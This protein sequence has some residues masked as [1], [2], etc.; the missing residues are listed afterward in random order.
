MP[1][2]HRAAVSVVTKAEIEA[3]VEADGWEDHDVQRM[4]VDGLPK[5]E[6]RLESYP[7]SR[8]RRISPR[9][10]FLRLY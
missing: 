2:N 1:T 8:N 3:E 5:R 9:S 10:V 4:Q 7:Y 6:T